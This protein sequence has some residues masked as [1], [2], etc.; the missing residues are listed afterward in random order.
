MALQPRDGLPSV[1]ALA[2]E[3]GSNPGFTSYRLYHVGQ[4]DVHLWPCFLIREVRLMNSALQGLSGQ[5]GE[6]TA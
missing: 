6:H 3:G 4:A 2:L 1:Q 5:N